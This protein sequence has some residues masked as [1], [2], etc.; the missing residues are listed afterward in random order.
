LTFKVK[1]KRLDKTYSLNSMQIAKNMGGEIL[2]HFSLFKVDVHHPY[3]EITIEIYNQYALFYIHKIKGMGG[4]PLGINGRVLLLMS[5]GIDSP[6]AGHLLMK[7]GMHVDF[8][9]FISPPHTDVRALNK[10]R[11]LRKL[12]TLNNKIE[13]A[14]LFIVNFTKLQHEISHI[15]NHSYQITIM[16]RY[17]IR[18]AMDLANKYHYDAIAT[19]ESLGQ[20]ASQTIESL[21]TINNVNTNKLILRPLLTYDKN[22]IISL[23]RLI[24]TYN[25]SILPYADACSLF[26]PTRPVTKPKADIAQKLE[27]ELDLIS[28]IYHNTIDKYITIE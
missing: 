17:F 9:T 1:A 28:D 13:C 24:N 3:L 8:L 26:V 18:V 22:E 6:V 20:V 10:V 15:S 7:K 16:R 4:F 12:L 27:L 5:G 2:K 23:A 11:K 21:T 25:T 19:G 14:K